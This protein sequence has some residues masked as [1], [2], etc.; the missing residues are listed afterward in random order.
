[1]GHKEFTFQLHNTNFYGEYWQVENAKATVI[2]VHGMGEHLKRYYHVA[3]K[4]TDNNFNVIAYD[5]F[6]HGKT[7]G[8]RGH[9]PNFEAL[10]DVIEFN[11]NKAVEISENLPVFLYG[12]SMGGNLVINYTIRKNH[13]LKGVIATS[14]FL[15]LAFEPPAWKMSLGKILQ[16]IAPSITLGNELNANHI[17][18][19][20][21]QVELYK[22]DPLVHDKISP[23]YSITILET[24]DWAINNAN[25]LKTPIFVIHGTDDKIISCEGSK[26]FCEKSDLAELQLIE[27]GYHELQNDI[28]KDEFLELV[29]NWTN[30]QV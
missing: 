19:D 5:N 15:K 30:Q 23:N 25:T 24:G 29:L 4:F 20:S 3:K 14:P 18:R 17:S 22:T 13:N 28:C 1:M 8:K 2:I 6:G 16:K 27:G 26:E 7:S 11:I 21:K 12:H 9:N 10:L